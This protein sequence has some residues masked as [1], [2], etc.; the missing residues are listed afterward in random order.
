VLTKL[1]LP[2]PRQEG[3]GLLLQGQFQQLSN[4]MDPPLQQTP[5]PLPRKRMKRRA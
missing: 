5:M 2:L 3:L 4:K 1:L